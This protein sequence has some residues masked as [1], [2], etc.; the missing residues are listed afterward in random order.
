MA[1]M[2]NVFMRMACYGLGMCKSCVFLNY[3]ANYSNL[4][5]SIPF[6]KMWFVLLDLRLKLCH[7]VFEIDYFFLLFYGIE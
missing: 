4:I 2:E 7:L 3:V 1:A 6:L 5:C